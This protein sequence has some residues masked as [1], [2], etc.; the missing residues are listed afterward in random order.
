MRLTT[1]GLQLLK[2]RP[3]LLNFWL[4]L[5][6][7]IQLLKVRPLL[8]NFWLSLVDSIAE[9]SAPEFL[10]E[11]GPAAESSAPVATPSD[12]NA[13]AAAAAER[14]VAGD[15]PGPGHADVNVLSPSQRK[16]IWRSPQKRNA[17]ASSSS[18][19]PADSFNQ[20]SGP[21]EIVPRLPISVCF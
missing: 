3:L 18:A 9:S 8:L 19:R 11:P 4:S 1:Q 6:Q 16:W 13:V 14:P 20:P 21:A 2:V 15:S 5:V 7:Q 12:P 10:V 17:A